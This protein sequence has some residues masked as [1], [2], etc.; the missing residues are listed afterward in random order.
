MMNGGRDIDLAL[1]AK[2]RAQRYRRLVML[3]RI[4]TLV[5]FLGLW[6]ILTDLKIVDPF[7]FGLSLIHISEPTRPY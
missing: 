3:G 4:G 7:F 1:L 2:Q 5:I 6:Q